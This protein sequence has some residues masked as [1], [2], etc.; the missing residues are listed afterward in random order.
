VAARLTRA[1]GFIDVWCKSCTGW[2]ETASSVARAHDVAVLHEQLVHPGMRAAY[3]NRAKYLERL[4]K[5][6]LTTL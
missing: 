4:R 2:S 5:I 6:N 1:P 3:M